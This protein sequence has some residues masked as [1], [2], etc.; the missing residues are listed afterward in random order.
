[1]IRLKQL[2]NEQNLKPYVST[3]WLGTNTWN[4]TAI[5]KCKNAKDLAAILKKAKGFL[6]D[7]EAAAE[8]VFMAIAN[9]DTD[10]NKVHYFY[11]EV[12]NNLGRIPYNYVKN[13]MDTSLKYHKQSIDISMKRIKE[14]EFDIDDLGLKTK[15][16][17]TIVIHG[18]DNI[19][20]YRQ[21]AR[22]AFQ[23]A[24]QWWR[25]YLSLPETQLNFDANWAAS[26]SKYP[27]TLGMIPMASGPATLSKDIF[28]LY[29]KHLSK[30]KL[31]FVDD[32]GVSFNAYVDP[33]HSDVLVVN[34]ALTINAQQNII[35]NTMIH[36]MQ[37][38]FFMIHP[39]NPGDKYENVGSE[40][41]IKTNIPLDAT[42]SRNMHAAVKTLPGVKL[43]DLMLWKLEAEA[44]AIGNDPKY[45]CRD[46]EQG[47]RVEY[48]R[49]LLGVNQFKPK[50]FIPYITRRM[51]TSNASYLLM[52]WA[53]QGFPNF[54][55]Y[56]NKLN[57]VVKTDSDSKKPEPIKL[58][59][60]VPPQTT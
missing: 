41:L 34:I 2:L 43:S 21:K 8:A 11:T 31:K 49:S 51:D 58:K 26:K 3:N 54:T 18:E 23:D 16:T 29:I 30:I 45:I 37:H 1:M 44:Q 60:L 47:S 10:I 59:S 25:T 28:P 35:K 5:E 53:Q 12:T 6:R 24:K 38:M 32:P 55:Q 40:T 7:D 52:C 42:T 15:V 57:T 22:N 9:Y 56:V 19:R 20:K 46:D 13:F 39:L 27:V 50:D 48:M 33:A 36:E 17:P 14:Y 4:Y